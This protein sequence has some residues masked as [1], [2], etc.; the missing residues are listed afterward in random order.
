MKAYLNFISTYGRNYGSSN[1]TAYRYRVFKENYQQIMTHNA[2]GNVVPFE[3]EV[4]EFT[5]FTEEEIQKMFTGL[6]FHERSISTDDVNKN[7]FNLFYKEDPN[8]PSRVPV[9][10]LLGKT[11]PSEINWYKEGKVTKP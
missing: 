1:A 9:F 3:M 8:K 7:Y 2:L 11:I 5:D 10:E 4:N 6:R